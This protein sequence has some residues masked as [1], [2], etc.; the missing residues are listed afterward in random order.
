[1]MILVILLRDQ[2]PFKIGNSDY[3]K[4]IIQNY[5]GSVSIIE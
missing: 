5:T 4:A 1:M 3:T 2:N